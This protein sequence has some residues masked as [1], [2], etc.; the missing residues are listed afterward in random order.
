[1]Y[2]T[3]EGTSTPDDLAYRVQ[4]TELCGLLHAGMVMSVVVVEPAEFDDWLEAK[5]ASA[6]KVK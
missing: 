5:S 4:C 1:M 3:P 2:V 6:M